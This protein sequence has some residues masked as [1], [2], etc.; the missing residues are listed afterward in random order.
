MV[1][2]FFDFIVFDFDVLF[3]GINFGLFVVVIGYY[4]VGRNNC[5]WCVFYFVGFMLMEILLLDDCEIFC[6]GCG[7]MVVV[8][9]LI[10]C[11]D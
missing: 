1:D 8:L 5:F 9:W 2:V 11:V 7:L 3:C 4:F 10:V 6:Y